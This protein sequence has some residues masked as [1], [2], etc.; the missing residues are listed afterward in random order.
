MQEKTNF[1]NDKSK[2][3]SEIKDLILKKDKPG[4]NRPGSLISKGH[5]QISVTLNFAM[6]IEC[7]ITQKTTEECEDKCNTGYGT[8]K[9]ER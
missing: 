4:K 2:L 6:P 1:R 3:S 5:R 8:N 9:K 7:S